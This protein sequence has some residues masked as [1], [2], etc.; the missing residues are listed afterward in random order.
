[1]IAPLRK[2]TALSGASSERATSRSSHLKLAELCRCTHALPRDFEDQ[3]VM[4]EIEVLQP[5]TEE[6]HL[7][8]PPEP[9]QVA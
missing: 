4:L 7:K 1:M 6:G 5:R 9:Q 2:Y 3:V 8:L